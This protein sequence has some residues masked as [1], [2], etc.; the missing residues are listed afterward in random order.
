MVVACHRAESQISASLADSIGLSHSKNQW[1][2]KQL[3]G[4]FWLLTDWWLNNLTSMD[5]Q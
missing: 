4:P 1:Y 5:D 3:F 2:L